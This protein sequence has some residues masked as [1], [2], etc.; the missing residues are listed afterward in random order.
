MGFSEE[1]FLGSPV[2]AN[3]PWMDVLTIQSE[4]CQQEDEEEEKPGDDISH[5]QASPNGTQ[6]PEQVDAELQEFT[7]L[8]TQIGMITTANLNRTLLIGREGE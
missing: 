2:S 7:S 1:P 5:N 4:A 8:S 6:K 3:I